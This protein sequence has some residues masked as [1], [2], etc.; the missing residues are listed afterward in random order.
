MA[1]R[2]I[3]VDRDT[4]AA[5]ASGLLFALAFPPV[6]LVLPAFVCLVPLGVAVAH[7]ADSGASARR[8]AALGFWFGLVG[9]GLNLYWIAIALSLF[10]WLASLG[11]VATI[12]G[13]AAISG[14]ATA[15]LF[16]VRR[17]TGW[18]MAILLPAVWVASELA[19]VH[20]GDIAF[21]WLPLG[22]ALAR[23]PVLAQAADLSGVHGLSAW[24][25]C[26]NG[27]L[28]DAWLNRS[29]RGAVVTR[30]AAA[31]GL[32]AV[33]A[34]YG[35][36][37]LRS[38][39]IFPLARVGAVQPNIPEDEKM[40]AAMRTRFIGILAQL[41]RDEIAH[42]DPQLVAWPETALPGY[43]AEEPSWR[44]TM[45]VLATVHHTPILFGVMDYE[46]HGAGPEDYDYFNAAM[47]ADSLGRIDTQPTYRK[48]Y[49]VPIVERVPFVNPRWFASLKYFGG[50]GRGTG[51]RPFRLPFGGVGVLICYESIFPD[52]AR[53]YRRRGADMLLN[54]TNDAWFGHTAAPYQHEAHLRLRAIENRVGIVR[55]ANTGISE[56]IDPLGRPHGATAL[57]TPADP[58]YAAETTHVRT[59]YVEWG[60]WLGALCVATTLSLLAL[61][62][63]ARFTTAPPPNPLP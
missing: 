1:R 51:V 56:Y 13:L 38:T 34:M 62:A 28:V 29:R 31:L 15:A 58:T 61:A 41:T 8:A 42:E 47:L 16:I 12:I 2:R 14:A 33:V 39:A 3:R 19:L 57:F 36:W 30:V 17:R 26:T 21:P 53:A 60:D 40:Q 59:L 27:L 24:V 49:L 9:C 4:W 48:R 46:L 7:A 6:P 11:Y 22:L 55:A 5:V 50:F 43:I 25:A 54:I 52:L 20:L 18:P 32:A 63:V 37:R 10:T 45:R 44:D 35:E 23:T